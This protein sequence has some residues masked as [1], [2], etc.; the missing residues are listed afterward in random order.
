MLFHE[1]NFFEGC[2]RFFLAAAHVVF[3]SLRV[4]IH[5]IIEFK[6]NK[7]KEVPSFEIIY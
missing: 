6:C 4:G 1:M 7:Y 3:N 5:K 2:K